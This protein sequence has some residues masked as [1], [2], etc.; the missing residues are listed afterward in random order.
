MFYRPEAKD[1]GLPHD[2]FKALVAPRPIGWISAMNSKGEINLAPYSFFNAV[3]D[4]PPTI[5]FSSTGWKD[6]ISFIEETGEFVCNMATYALREEMNLTSAPFPTGV[7]E[8]EKAGLAAAPSMLV[9]P[10]RVAAS[11][12]ALEC[13]LLQTIQLRTLDGALTNRFMVLGQVIGVY[14]DERF[15]KDGLVN[16][17][18]MMPIL[19]AGYH[20]YFTALSGNCFTM[21]RPT[22]A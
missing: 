14:I 9:R 18:A 2:P 10:P 5:M 21:E 11:P 4:D 1:H 12:A 8:M 16:T 22:T 15:I 17:A 13:R 19:R 7:N 20:E 3:N 6:A